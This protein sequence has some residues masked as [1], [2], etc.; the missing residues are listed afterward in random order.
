MRQKLLSIL[1]LLCLTVT[2]AWAD[3][4]TSFSG[5]EVLKPGDTFSIA[6]GYW[7]INEMMF[8]ASNSP[9][10]VLRANIMP[11]ENPWDPATVTE[12]EDGNFFVIKDYNGSYYFTDVEKMN[13]L[14][15]MN[16]NTDPATPYDGIEVYKNDDT[17]YF[18]FGHQAPA[19]TSGYCGDP[20]VN[21]GEDVTWEVDGTTITIS[22]TGAMAD[23]DDYYNMAPWLDNNIHSYADEI[24]SIV[25]ESGVT[26]IGSYAFKGCYYATSISIPT[27]V[28][29]IG[30]YAF[31]DCNYVT[32]ISIPAGVMTIGSYA[33]ENCYYAESISI[34]ASVTS[35]GEKA[36][37]CCGQSADTHPTVTIADGSQLE[38]IGNSAFENCPME[39][40]TIPDG[41]KTIGG[42]AFRYCSG[43]TS[44]NIPASVTSIGENA[45]QY[46]LSLATITLNGNPYMHANAFNNIANNGT[47]TMN[48]TATVGTTGEYW[49]TFYNEN[50]SFQVPTTGTQIFK[51][52]PSGSNL[53]LTELSADRV[54]TKNNAVILK[55]AT[56]SIS[57]RR[58]TAS[59]SSNYTG[60]GLQGV[61]TAEGE[62]S[63]GTFYALNSGTQGVGFY[64][65]ASGT[66]V[67]LGNAYVTSDSSSDFLPFVIANDV[68]FADGL[69]DWTATPAPAAEGETVTLNYSGKKKVK[70]ITVT[71]Q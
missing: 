28:T 13:L 20:S 25:I 43:L 67:A 51:A 62:E 49:L 71:N 26:T 66:K 21:N 16:N 6:E 41:V 47:V 5:G 45:F 14:P 34:P 9:F 32:S 44:M 60:N 52:T 39:S 55:S 2:S 68:T 65:V 38:T 42:S 23:Y 17:Q 64:P 59:S 61:K 37:Y 63:D 40:F 31:E 48:L 46:S 36:F 30:S 11:G 70:S 1:A 54:V 29:T 57:L 7:E 33:F 18:F 15:V 53:L 19:A 35:I 27:S 4:Y 12:Y 58:T 50:H 56:A 10:T 8:D 22:G 24:T 3:N 69:T